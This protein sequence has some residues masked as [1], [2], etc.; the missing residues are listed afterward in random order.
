MTLA[1]HRMAFAHI[2]LASDDFGLKFKLFDFNNNKNNNIL[3]VVVVVVVVDVVV[4]DVVVV[5][6]VVVVD[7][8]MLSLYRYI[9]GEMHDLGRP[10]QDETRPI[11]IRP[12]DMEGTSRFALL[13]VF[14]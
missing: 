14:V 12:Y 10:M 4:V 2:G 6:V 7:V 8:F 11:P 9:S 13:F 3:S 1:G 5:V